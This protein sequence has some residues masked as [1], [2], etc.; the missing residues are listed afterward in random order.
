MSVDGYV[1]GP[2]DDDPNKPGGDGFTL[3]EW[4]L[5]P[6]GGFR[7]T[8]PEGDLMGEILAAGAVVSG[9]RTAEHAEHWG[10]VHHGDGVPVFVL[11][12]RP[13]PPAIAD[14]PLITYVTDGIESAMA[15]A[16]AAAGDRNVHVI[17]A[18]TAQG[19]LEA[20]LLD[21]IQLHVVPVLFG[22]GR[23]LIDLLPARVQLEIVQVIDT[24]EATHLRYRVRR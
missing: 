6:E 23:R 4:G 11:S 21:E 9:R 17:G 3:H 20:G 22:G 1:A 13:A 8:G 19:A 14:Y 10:G 15:Q 24:P 16:K 2:N 5:T 7:E 18:Q 12:H